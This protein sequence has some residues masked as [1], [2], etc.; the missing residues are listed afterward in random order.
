MSIAVMT[1]VWEHS[2]QRGGSL[3]ILLALADHANDEGLCWPG[4]ERLAKKSRMSVRQV[5]RCLEALREAGEIAVESQAGP[6]GTNQYTVVLAGDKMSRPHL[7]GGRQKQQNR[8]DI[9]GPGMSPE[10]S[11][12]IIQPSREER[13]DAIPKPH[14]AVAIFREET[15][16]Y[17]KR[18]L[19]P[20]IEDAVG[21]SEESLELWRRVIHGWIAR[22]YSKVNIEGP[23]QWFK[24]GGVPERGNG[25]ALEPKG[26]A[27][28]REYDRMTNRGN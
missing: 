24:A 18:S 14:P 17:P 15:G 6:H 21:S 20:D 28:I 11:V 27:A 25:K 7:G 12:T 13:A 3:L 22:G 1:S 26:F 4:L 23:L 10:P 9:S 2:K 19:K 16:L 5:Q 8:G